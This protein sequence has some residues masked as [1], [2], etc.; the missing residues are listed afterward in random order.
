[1]TSLERSAA[2]PLRIVFASLLRAD[3]LVFLKHRRALVVSLLLPMFLLVT[4]NSDKAT[5][6]FGGAVF[7]VGLAI[8]YGLAA[9]S[10]VGYALTVARDRENG[11]F[12][13]L[14]VTPAPTWTVM[15]SRLVMQA[16]ANLIL[17]LVVV[18][19]GARIHNLSPSIGQYVLVL[20]VSL[21]GGAMFLSIAQALVGL[22]RSAETVQA[23]ARVLLAVL[24]LL[25][26]LG[27]SGA[28]GSAWQEIARWSPV[29][30]VMTLFAGV[31]NLHAWGSRET[32]SLVV[33]FGYIVIC[34]GL[35]IRWFRWEAR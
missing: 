8:A 29:G 16:V 24:I 28:A 34:A 10:I 6:R 2:P 19:V 32:L 21:L 1:V 7:I 13:R 18:V 35:G 33:S 20:L 27:Q 12:Q 5:H 14:R 31:L 26:T 15:T 23:I 25:G 22:V 9:T 30:T 17:S 3:F 4:T 11:V